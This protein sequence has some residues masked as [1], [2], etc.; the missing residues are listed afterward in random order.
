MFSIVIPTLQKD[1]KI[2]KMLLDEL[3]Q[4]QTVGEIILIDNSLQG[5]EYNSDKLRIIVPNENLFVNQSW[6]LGVE[7][8][9]FDYVGILN[10][11]I[12]LP[13]NLVSDV[14]SFLQGENIGLV[15]IDKKSIFGY[16]PEEIKAYP[17]NS[18]IKYL[19]IK[20]DLYIGYWGV[21]IFGKKSNFSEIPQEMKIWCGDNF[22]LKTNQD[23]YR[24]NFKLRCDKIIHLGSLSCGTSTLDGIKKSD[25]EFYSTID[26]QFKNHDCGVKKQTFLNKIFTLTNS[27][28]RRRKLLTIF[29]HTFTIKKMD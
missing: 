26:P 7:K 8:A 1:T 19:P 25:I 12:L 18:E 28:D 9:K 2:L 10:D 21:A 20:N 27:S 15:G 5:F 23:K 3:N 14:Y 22:L 11:D 24:K 16:K 4:D 17:Q 6:N 29:G 13:K